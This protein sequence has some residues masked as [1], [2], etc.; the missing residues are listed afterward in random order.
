MSL[1]T[2]ETKESEKQYS[3]DINAAS[4]IAKESMRKNLEQSVGFDGKGI[5]SIHQAP[6][7]MFVSGQ[8]PSH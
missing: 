5:S 4:S 7:Y 8:F 1:I 3:R 6:E 2:V